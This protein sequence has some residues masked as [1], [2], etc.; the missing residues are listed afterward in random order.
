VRVLF[1]R[2]AIGPDDT[3]AIWY[4]IAAFSLGLPATTASRLL[5]NALYALGDAR[6]PA[7]LAAVRVS[8]A[9]LLGLALMFPLDRL[10]VVDGAIRGWGDI[11]ALGP[12]GEAARTSTG[13]VP[14]LGIVGLA[15]GAAVSSWLEYR[16]LS[17]AVAWR[18]G[19]SRLGGRWLNPISAACIVTALVAFGLVLVFG[20]LYSLISAPLILGPAALAYL[21]VAYALGVPE[22][23][24]MF[25][26]IMSLAGR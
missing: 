14:H 4:V 23:K 22:A 16:M 15:L 5:Q 26:R 19:R 11:F 24:S 8:V 17:T 6:T 9:A 20:D 2:G 7:R 21:G 12:L 18:I 25:G 13:G 1:Q 3:I 10:T